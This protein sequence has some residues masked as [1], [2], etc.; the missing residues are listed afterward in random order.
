MMN[1][2]YQGAWLLHNGALWVLIFLCVL[3]SIKLGRQLGKRIYRKSQGTR[4]STD[5][6]LIGAILGLM[7]LVLAF[8]FSGAANRLD[9]RERLIMAETFAIVNAYQ[10]TLHLDA[11][12]QTQ[13][14][15]L[16]AKMMEQRLELYDGLSSFQE[17]DRRQAVVFATA[18]KI[19]DAAFEASVRLPPDQKF[20]ATRYMNL[21]GAMIQ[22]HEAQLEAV[23]IHPPRTIWFSLLFLVM[24]GS[25]LAGYK[26][27][28]SQK[29]DHLLSLIFAGLIAC[30]V[31]LTLSLEF[32]LLFGANHLE[33]NVR[34]AI[35]LHELLAQ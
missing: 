19:Q 12:A 31:Y 27:G 32:P 16:F 35:R 28:I 9:Q 2:V 21:V 4:N 8:T 34:Q 1:S 29:R 6:T 15:P 11:Q 20:M 3:L 7:A 14:R 26:M 22:A 10:S 30:A 18:L 5:D 17:F 23:R 13:L 25:F 33:S 24:L